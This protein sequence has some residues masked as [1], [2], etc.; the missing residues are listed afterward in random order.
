MIH[1]HTLHGLQRT[2]P[3]HR[4]DPTIYYSAD[5][6]V[7]LLLKQNR[8]LNRPVRIGVVGMGV[9]T[10]A[11]YG[12]KGDYFRFYEIDPAV[13]EFSLGPRPFFTFVQGSAADSDIVFGDARINLQQELSKGEA[14]NFD[15]LAVDA[16]TGD[17]VPVHLLTREAMA[18]YLH[19]LRGPDSV[20]AFHLS[21]TAIDL[22]PVVQSLASFY[23]LASIEVDTTS[24][25]Q[26]VW[27]LVARDPTMLRSPG[28]SAKSH[29]VEVRKVVRPWTDDYSSPYELLNW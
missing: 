6:G 16:F 18:L 8:L 3:A 20:I 5:S 10:L 12:R 25:L 15:L 14:Q 29:E 22:R 11:A 27:V 13:P 7:G 24:D 1:G 21:S 26:P 23:H 9:G 28:L 17:T 2:D 19:H 4:D